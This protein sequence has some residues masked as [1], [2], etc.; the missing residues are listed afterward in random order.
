[1]YVCLRVY[2]LSVKMPR[3]TARTH[4]ERTQQHSHKHAQQHSHKHAHADTELLYTCRDREQTRTLTSSHTC[5]M[6]RQHK[7]TH[8]NTHT[9]A[10]SPHTCREKTQT[11]TRALGGFARMAA[12]C[13]GCLSEIASSAAFSASASTRK[14]SSYCP[15]S[16]YSC[17]LCTFCACVSERER[18]RA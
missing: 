11:L 4:A 18:S 2:M 15:S 7:N 13:C 5:H 6:P 1:M 8:A 17:A 3:P 12:A 9:P 16:W 14:A 10:L